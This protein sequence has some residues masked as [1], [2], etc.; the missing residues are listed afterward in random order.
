MSERIERF[1]R[2]HRFLSNFFRCLVEHEGIIYSTVE[3]AFQA[4]KTTDILMRTGFWRNNWTAAQAKRAGRL[5]VLRPDWEQVKVGVMRDCL[6]SKF[7][8]TPEL[9]KRLRETGDAEIIEG[10]TWHDNI[11]GACSCARC[12]ASGWTPLNL[13]GKLLE[14]TREWLE[15]R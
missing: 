1:T 9:G 12:K 5:L 8:T 7:T 13:L 3:H 11:W 4:A 2:E 15:T 14:E 10:N 6:Q